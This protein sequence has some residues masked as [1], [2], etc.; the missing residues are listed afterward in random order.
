VSPST[1]ACLQLRHTSVGLQCITVMWLRPNYGISSQHTVPLRTAVASKLTK[2][3]LS[4][5]V[6]LAPH[7]CAA[8]RCLPANPLPS[9]S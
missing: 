4:A 7:K 2:G 6:V 8:L 9:V 5:L 3:A 1:E